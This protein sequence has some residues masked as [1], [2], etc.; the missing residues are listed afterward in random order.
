MEA[1]RLPLLYCF[2]VSGRNDK[3]KWLESGIYDTDYTDTS[4]KYSLVFRLNMRE[5]LPLMSIQG[6]IILSDNCSSPLP[7]G[8]PNF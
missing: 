1:Q 8:S 6:D 4:L 3:V 2:H 7:A 5:E